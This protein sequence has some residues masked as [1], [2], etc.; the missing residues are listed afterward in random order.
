MEHKIS[1][2]NFL[3]TFHSIFKLCIEMTCLGKESTLEETARIFNS[4]YKESKT[5]MFSLKD[6]SG[7][8]LRRDGIKINLQVLSVEGFAVIGHLTIHGSKA[9]HA[10]IMKTIFERDRKS[11]LNLICL[12]VYLTIINPATIRGK[13]MVTL[14]GLDIAKESIRNYINILQQTTVSLQIT[15]LA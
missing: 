3:W 8:R 6:Q 10:Y 12:D 7:T 2:C 15:V 9:L 11:N 14:Q 4:T 5:S 1:W 13:V